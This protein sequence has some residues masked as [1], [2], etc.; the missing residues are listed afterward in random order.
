MKYKV[1]IRRNLD[2]VVR[3]HDMGNLEWRDDG[4]HWWWTEGN[5]GCDCNREWEF[6]R[7]GGE[8]ISEE[9]ECGTSRYTVIRAIFEDGSERIID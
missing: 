6:Q 7:A 3:L 9:S 1:E 5:F 8:P 2:G 4:T